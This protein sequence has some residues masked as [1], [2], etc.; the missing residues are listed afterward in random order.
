MKITTIKNAI[1]R[2]FQPQ[3]VKLRIRD[4]VR[5]PVR[6]TGRSHEQHNELKKP[7]ISK[8]FIVFHRSR[9]A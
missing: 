7:S 1:Y 3:K 9:S 4:L 6:F 2:P 5:D 8:S